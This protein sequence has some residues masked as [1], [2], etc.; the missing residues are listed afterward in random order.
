MK[1]LTWKLSTDTAFRNEWTAL[2]DTAGTLTVDAIKLKLEALLLKW[3]GAEGINPASRGAYVD[4]RHLA[5]LEAFF[6][7]EY[8]EV[9][10]KGDLNANFP[11]TAQTGAALKISLPPQRQNRRKR[12][13]CKSV[14]KCRLARKSA[15][16][17]A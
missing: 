17:A 14:K 1:D 9:Q 4:G 11:R 10:A 2:A 6:G 5:F 13:T 16:L 12:T 15:C 7:E 3:A 8:R